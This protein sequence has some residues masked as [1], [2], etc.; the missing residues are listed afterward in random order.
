MTRISQRARYGAVALA[1]LTSALAA[2]GSSTPSSPWASKESTP[3]SLDQLVAD[4][5]AEGAL[6]IFTP[7][8]QS[9]VEEWTSAFTQ[10]YGVKVNIQRQASSTLA[11]TFS[12][13]QRAN[14]VEAD[15]YQTSNL[16]QVNEYIDNKWFAKYTP[17]SANQFPAD[18]TVPGY[19]YPL[20]ET[21]G[22]IAW[23]TKTVPQS[24]QD[25]LAADPYEGLLDPAL[26]GKIVLID[27][28]VGGSGM[29]Y[30]ANLAVNLA[31][32]YGW[33]YLEKL[34]AQQPAVTTSIQTISQQVSAGTYSATI[35]GDDAI[36][37]PLAASGAP[38][39]FASISPM[40]ASQFY[41]EI[42]S[43]APHPAAARL[44]DEWSESLAGQQA[45]SVATG[46]RSTIE[47]WQE[48]RPFVSKLP[49]Y[50][51]PDQVWVDWQ[52]DERFSGD[53]LK[54]FV[55]KWNQTFHVSS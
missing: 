36:F 46:G 32:R 11:T 7:I 3:G 29:A 20:Y 4:A 33:G 25:K 10:K 21:T 43:K 45:M 42:P 27:P 30:Y 28:G 17:Q 31:D 6:T 37:G 39:R 18:R 22:A 54:S 52:R 16:G 12:T 40:N 14:K 23:N 50:K 34:A 41:Q 51:A 53:Q 38:V 13:Q 47:G 8:V 2:C 48:N 24:T 5:K 26:K 15:I 49:W 35:F 55:E 9:E 44:F 1:L 19:A